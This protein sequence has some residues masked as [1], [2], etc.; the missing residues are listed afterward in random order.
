M[1]NKH[2][3]NAVH[4]GNVEEV[5]QILLLYPNI[6]I[7]FKGGNGLTQLQWASQYGHQKIIKVLVNSGAHIETKDEYGRTLLIIAS[8]DG[9]CEAMKKLIKLGAL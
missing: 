5:R 8:Q 2:L 4:G 7:D 9:K 1:E 3:R 6:N